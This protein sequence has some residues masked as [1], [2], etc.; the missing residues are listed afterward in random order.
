MV[1]CLCDFK[2]AFVRW[3]LELWL[4]LP[5][6]TAHFMLIHTINSDF[7]CNMLTNWFCSRP[8][9]QKNEFEVSYLKLQVLVT[10]CVGQELCQPVSPQSKK[11]I[12]ITR[13][14]SRMG[15]YLGN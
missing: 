3:L 14:E 12:K 13:S 8:S 9:S 2:I 7:C 5:R 6:S 10:N 15:F 1:G 11:L 4:L